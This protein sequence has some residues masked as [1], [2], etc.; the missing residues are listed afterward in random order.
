MYLVDELHGKILPLRVGNLADAMSNF[1]TDLHSYPHL[2]QSILAILFCG[3]NLISSLRL[4][5][6]S[7]PTYFLG[8]TLQGSMLNGFRVFICVFNL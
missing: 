3:D 7:N 8:I 4:P 5:S 6:S 2:H 1:E